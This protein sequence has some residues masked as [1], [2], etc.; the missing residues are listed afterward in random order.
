MLKHTCYILVARLLVPF[1]AAC[2]SAVVIQ[3]LV[4]WTLQLVAM[5]AFSAV[6]QTACL[7][8]CAAGSA[9]K[10]AADKAPAPPAPALPSSVPQAAQ[11]LKDAVPDLSAMFKDATKDGETVP[12]CKGQFLCCSKACAMRTEVNCSCA[13]LRAAKSTVTKAAD[14]APTPAAPA[15]PQEAKKAADTG[16]EAP[17]LHPRRTSPVPFDAVC[18]PVP[19]SR[20]FS[21]ALSSW[22]ES[23]LSVHCC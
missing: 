14:Q 7:L 12:T 4:R 21:S 20:H 3:E 1:D 15:P 22:Q 9:V 11:S 5:L 8:L 19:R 23:L 18:N 13:C 6:E 2:N 10:A 17:M 16:V